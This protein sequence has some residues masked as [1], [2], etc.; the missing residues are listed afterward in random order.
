MK[1]QYFMLFFI[2]L[3]Y[4][5]SAQDTLRLNYEEAQRMLLQQ[6]LKVLASYYEISMAEADVVQSK[7][8]QN[9][10]F[11]WNQDIFNIP[12]NDYFNFQNQF[13][14]QVEQ[15]FSVSGKHLWGVRLAKLGVKQNKI[16]LQDVLRGLLFEL[17]EK[18]IALHTAQQKRN[19]YVQVLNRYDKL[20]QSTENKLKV[21]AISKNEVVR[22][23]SEKITLLND[24]IHNQNDIIEMSSE[25]RKLLNIKENIAI[26]IPESPFILKDESLNVDNLITEALNTRPDLSLAKLNIEYS[27]ANLKSEKAQA[28]P[29]LKLGYQPSDRGSNY[30]LPYQGMLFEA[31]IPI[32]DRNQGGIKKAKLKIEQSKIN[33]AQVDNVVRNDVINA[34]GQW[35]NIKTGIQNFTSNLLSEMQEI[36]KNS[37]L[38]YENK[39]INLLQYIDL[40]RIYTQNQLEYIEMQKKFKQSINRLNFSV[41]KEI[42]KF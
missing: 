4:I 11:S 7:L 21:G 1:K 9:P 32:F 8:W 14:I 41:G 38:N 5:V 10:Y 26:S 34:F 13:S 19:L 29:D 30:V 27:D 3:P 6:N 39:N 25:I 24:V 23:K 2:I 16:Q 20:I 17:G 36:S 42:I 31:S 18:Y 35:T 22:L 15:V 37:D 33:Y 40:Q 12:K 28:T